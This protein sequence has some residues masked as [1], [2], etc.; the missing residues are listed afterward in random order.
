MAAPSELKAAIGRQQLK[1]LPA[2]VQARMDNWNSLR[3]GLA[4]LEEH[5]SFMLPTHA[6]GWSQSG[7]FT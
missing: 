5:F 3:A 4:D 7:G 2:F 6:T 1:K